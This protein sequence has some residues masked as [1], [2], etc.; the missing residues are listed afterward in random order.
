MAT[1]DPTI[2]TTQA[3]DE[4]GEGSSRILQTRGLTKRF[5]GLTA[6]DDVDFA[7]DAGELRCLIGP[8]GAGKSTF[9]KLLTGRHDPSAGAIYYNGA[10]L[11]DLPP[12]KRIDRGISIKFQVPSVYPDLT[13]EENLRIPLQRVASKAEFEERTIETL[14]QFDLLEEI[15]TTAANLSHGQQQRLEIGMAMTL[16]P[17][18]MLLD[19]PVAGLS[20]EETEEI[21]E[22]LVELNDE[23]VAFIVIEHDIDF[24]ASIA[25][26]VTVL[27]QGDIFTEGTIEDVRSDP[28]V[29][30]IYLG[31]D[32]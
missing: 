23:D 29:K 14:E 8:N 19:E 9:L 10:E 15:D 16:E 2:K 17:D 13:V 22:L 28:E 18:L 21:A 32:H 7:V 24:V 27:H 4:T 25:D 26:R 3:V 12:Y 6:I 5:G 31:E 30:K 11:T 20:V 1:S